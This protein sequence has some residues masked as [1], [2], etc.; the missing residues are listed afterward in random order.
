[1]IDSTGTIQPHDDRKGFELDMD[2]QTFR[3]VIAVRFDFV[4]SEAPLSLKLFF[5][6]QTK[7]GIRNVMHEDEHGFDL[8]FGPALIRAHSLT[9]G[10]RVPIEGVFSVR[11]AEPL[12]ALPVDATL[13]LV[14]K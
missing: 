12:K 14:P 7:G 3:A 2:T 1:M 13:N 10:K 11:F 9:T 5:R 6:D 4:L 8:V